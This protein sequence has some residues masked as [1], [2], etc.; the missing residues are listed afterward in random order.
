MEPRSPGEPTTA[1]ELRALL[2]LSWPITVAQLMTMALGLVETAIVG[3]VSTTELAG[4]AIGR[5]VAFTASMV[6]LG[7]ATGL[8]PLASQAVG[9]GEPDRAW[10]GLLTTLQAVLLMWAPL[11]VLAIGATFLFEPLGIDHAIAVRARDYE[12][13]QAP[14]LAFVIVFFAGKVFLQ[15]HGRTRPAL[16]AAA[17][18][19]AVNLVV[20]NVLVRGDDALVAVGLS[21]RNLPRL[22]ALGAGIAFSVSC[23]VLAIIV[24]AA[25]WR[26]RPRTRS[27]KVPMRL[28]MR[29]GLPV[30]F[31]S[32][33]EVGV[34]TVCALLI[35]RFGA[36][37]VSA[38]QIAIGLASFT[39]MGALGVSGAT[40]VRVGYAVGQAR[41]PRR[42]GLLGIG[43]GV[44]FMALGALAFAA[45]PGPLVGLFTEDPET[46]E[47]GKALLL[48][49]AAFQLFDGAQAV[50][51]GALRGAGD[52]RFPF[53]ANVCAHWAVGFPAACVFGFVLGWG[54]RGIW[55]G[56]TS[57]LVCV[58]ALLAGRFLRIS[59]EA[60]AR[61]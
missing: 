35:G 48:I 55:W 42:A 59:R 15:A 50:A 53:V 38:H 4:V 12:I 61:V 2:V 13:G 11:M 41:S 20:C 30:G 23:F 21:P 57:G 10:A 43:L 7:V 39:F 18:A 1:E 27:A 45:V 22:G 6:A 60:I 25:A 32:L 52:V 3:R 29:L 19:N 58:S 24:L 14:G 51:A 9:A 26:I 34:F 49:A 31:Q 47:L 28:T 44:G 16:L 8:E 54:V 33:A 40:A 5:A 46:I 36:A 56:L 17:V 37:A